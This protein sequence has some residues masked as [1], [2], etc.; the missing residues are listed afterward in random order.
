MFSGMEASQKAVSPLRCI[1]ATLNQIIIFI[2]YINFIEIN[3]NLPVPAI[4]KLYP[5][6]AQSSLYEK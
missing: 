3:R 1:N 4:F 2:Y 6:L 5:N